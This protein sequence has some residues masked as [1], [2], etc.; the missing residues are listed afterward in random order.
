MK[1]AFPVILFRYFFNYNTKY[2]A[3]ILPI[4]LSLFYTLLIIIDYLIILEL[5][6]LWSYF[7]KRVKRL[8][9][10]RLFYFYLLV[11]GIKKKVLPIRKCLFSVI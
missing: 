1:R 9:D 7:K 8:L 3:Y 10:H 5:D 4:I 6:S 2:K 11:N